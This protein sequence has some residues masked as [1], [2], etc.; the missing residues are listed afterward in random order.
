M[1]GRRR[2]EARLFVLALA[3][4]TAL[5]FGPGAAGPSGTARGASPACPWMNTALSPQQR[6]SELVAAMTIDQKLAMLSQSQPIWQHY[7]VAGYIPAQ[8]SLCIPDLVLN[9]AGQGVGDQETG[10]TAFP[11][12]IAQSS[13]WDPGLQYQFGQALGWEAWHKG[14]NVQLAPG[15]EIDR[16]PLNGRNYEYMSEDPYLSARGGVAEIQGIQS[17]PVIAT[18]K[19]FVANSQETNRMTD[20]AD[21]DERTLQEIYLPAYEA[22]V[23]Q[24]QVG[25]VMC[26]YNRINDVYACENPHLLTTVLKHQ[27]GFGGFVMSDWGGTHST[28]PAANAGLDMEMNVAPGTY[29]A[30]PLKAAV[31]AGQ[32][33]MARL[34]DMVTRIVGA[35]FRLGI[36]D[37]PAAAEPAAAAANV[38]R[39]QDIALARTISEEGTVLLKN[40]NHVLPLT[41]GGQ[42]I[43][44]IG[45]GAGTQGAE[46]FYNGNGSG[47]VPELTGKA[48]VVSPLQG[49]QQRAAA[50]GDTV[51][52]ADGS[53]AAAA[54]ATAKLANVAVVFVGAQD[55][56]GVDRTTLDLSS[57]D[58]N[59]AG[60]CTP[61]PIDQDQ[62]ISQVA[63]ANPHTIVVLNTGGPVVM[64]WLDQIQG[65]FEAWYP[66]QEDGNA[67]AAL[68]Y[69][70]VNPSAKLPET[71]PRSQ[72]DIPTQ[73][74]QQFPGVND[75]QGVPQSQYSEG[76]LVG[77]RWYDAKQI[78]PLF[79]FGYGLSYTSFNY[80]GLKI[81]PASAGAGV[82]VA[83]ASIAVT[84]TGQ[85]SGADVP[86]LYIAAPAATGEPPKQ[87]KGFQ[88]IDLAAGHT[89]QV[90]F[91]IDDRALSY[92]STAASGWQVAPGCYAIMVGHDE[93]DIAQQATVSVNG[94]TCPGAV[95]SL[96]TRAAALQRCSAPRGVLS[97]KRL[98]P[99]ALGMT[100]ARIRRTLTGRAHRGLRDM[101]FFCLV[102][103]GGIRAGFPSGRLLRTLRPG[104]RRAVK[105]RAVLL[106]TANPHYALSGVR[107]GQ[108]VTV[109]RTHL[110]L[111]RAFRIGRNTWY[112]TRVR[113][114]RRGVLRVQHGLVLE[115]GITQARLTASR[116]AGRRLLASFS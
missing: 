46:Q 28:V 78:A 54:A 74:P 72:A 40:D 3:A 44:V 80:S 24:G 4:A 113:G 23:Q 36:F 22:A 110:K 83:T 101:D 37:H 82:T 79:P 41:G 16:I 94:A 90:S 69:G 85:R 108:P 31:Q 47:H 27:F 58:C 5:L 114:G 35:M 106:L 95:A 87:L 64:P 7:G 34:D 100:R 68:L 53:N 63:A 103:G 59:L 13:S 52:Y 20:S 55:S 38:E 39:P 115:V 30:A 89:G 57:G 14:I 75:A 86:Q 26:S 15:V 1:N 48:E 12:P 109:A 17:N 29:F 49:I 9:D 33:T 76:L 10:T 93:R 56:E 43:A 32:V 104:L 6:A 45:P 8:P 98:G 21:V 91:P 70:D 60:S 88:R 25:S 50:S 18:V 71:F 51:L 77:Y 62:L 112:L 105:G 65:L 92:W 67:I 116:S 11:A 84:N 73:T 111:G 61:Q 81:T 97:Q 2:R 102:G 99:V 107:A 42:R 66:G 19:H 96:S